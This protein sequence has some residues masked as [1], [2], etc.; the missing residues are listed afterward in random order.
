[1]KLLTIKDLAGFK[2]PKGYVLFG[3]FVDPTT[4]EITLRML[5]EVYFDVPQP[6]REEEVKTKDVDDFDD[7]DDGIIGLDQI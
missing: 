7:E 3:A 1:M 5:P 4:K 6:K 2:P